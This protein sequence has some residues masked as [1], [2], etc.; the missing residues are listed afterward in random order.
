VRF[1]RTTQ[2]EVICD[3][4]GKQN[5][6]GAYLCLD[7]ACFAKAKKGRALQRAFSSELSEQD[8]TRLYSEFISLCSSAKDSRGMVENG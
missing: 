3:P 7:E 4:S 6:R 2:G 8:Y 1:V 5:G